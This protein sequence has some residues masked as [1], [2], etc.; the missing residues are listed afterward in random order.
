MPFVSVVMPTRNE[1]TSIGRSLGAVLEQDYPADRFEVVVADGMSD[2][3]T[4]TILEQLVAH[5][6]AGAPVVTVI[7]N[8]GRI[9]AS[10][11]NRAIS[12]ARGDII[13]RVDAHCV[14]QEDHV[15]RCVRLLD[16]HGAENVG[17]VQEATGDGVVGRAIAAGTSSPFGVGNA[18]FRYGTRAGWVD[19]VYL[20]AWRRSTFD[21]LGGFDEDL[22]RNQDDEFNFRTVQQGGRIWFDPR[23]RTE[24]EVRGSLAG[25]WRQY[26]G[27]GY[28]KVLVMRKRR[29]VASYRHLAPA[30]FVATVAV[31]AVTALVT[32]RTKVLAWVIAPY[33]LA[34]TAASVHAARDDPAAAACLPVVF[35]CL[36]TSYGIGFL[37][38]ARRWWHGTGP[39]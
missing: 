7:D 20:G 35:A 14:V 25:L 12:R 17:G 8:P 27:Y 9:A 22:V 30:A 18:R 33:V 1:A 3:G 5:T 4:R 26:Y 38:G 32:R 37:A 15:S 28:Y 24:Y 6:G 39:R 23:I 19:T 36:H 16:E 13:V 31:A 29:G 11:L 21:R 34:S 2:D 10:G